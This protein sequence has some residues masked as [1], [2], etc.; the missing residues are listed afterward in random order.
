MK[1]LRAYYSETI[2]RFLCQSDAEILGTIHGNCISADVTIQQCNTWTQEI[3][4]LKRQLARLD[5]GHII[6]EY[7]I[8]RMGKRV[9]VVILHKNI[10]FLLEFK[11]GDHE[12]RAS[13]VD[14]V[15]NYALDLRNFQKESHN[16]LIANIIVST[17][18]PARPIAIVE[19]ERIIE[20]ICCNAG[21]IAEAISA[22]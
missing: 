22:V 19:S 18:A 21:N 8:P 12:Y 17:N 1:N 2:E 6:F 9:D 3:D 11:C 14:Q 4:I 10:V 5:E 13:S 15:Y 7:T 16:K 20:P